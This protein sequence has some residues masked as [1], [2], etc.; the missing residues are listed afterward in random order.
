MDI[1]A[2]VIEAVTAAARAAGNWERLKALLDA[3]ADP[4]DEQQVGVLI[5]TLLQRGAQDPALAE[6]LNRW[7]QE[8][9]QGM[10]VNVVGGNATFNGPVIQLPSIDGSINI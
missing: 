7:A 9:K 4:A 1:E 3:E 8:V 10:V 5:A 2:G 6:E